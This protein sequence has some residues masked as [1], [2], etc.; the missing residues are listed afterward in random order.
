MAGASHRKLVQLLITR[1]QALGYRVVASDQGY[2]VLGR[3]NVPTPPLVARHSPDVIGARSEDPIICVGEAKTPGDLRS[4]HTCEQLR[5]F[6][7]LPDSLVIVAV[8]F[9]AL[10]KLRETLRELGIEESPRFQCMAVP[11]ELIRG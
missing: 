7:S 10:A 8:P 9:S 6:A 1:M 2:A 5:D 3:D 4:R 11:D